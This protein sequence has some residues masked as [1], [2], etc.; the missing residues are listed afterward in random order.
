M[1]PDLFRDPGSVPYGYA[2]EPEPEI[3]L[4]AQGLIWLVLGA[5]AWMVTSCGTGGAPDPKF[6]VTPAEGPAPLTV[7]CDNQTPERYLLGL[8]AVQW[9]WS[10]G[11][12]TADS[13]ERAPVHTY[14]QPGEYT[15]RLTASTS[16]GRRSAE[17][18]VRVTVPEPGDNGGGESGGGEGGG[19]GGSGDGGGDGVADIP[20]RFSR[21]FNVTT[22]APALPVDVTI[23]LEYQGSAAMTALGLVETLPEGWTFEGVVSGPV[24]LVRQ[25][26]SDVEFAWITI[27]AFPVSVTYR[28]RAPADLA[29][30]Q[31]FSGLLRYRFAAGE[32]SVGPVVTTLPVTDG[33]SS[34]TPSADV[35]LTRNFSTEGVYTPGEPVTVTVTVAYT[36]LYP[37]SSLGIRETLPSGWV[38]G[39][40]GGE[41]PP[42][43]YR[44]S[45]QNAEFAW[46]DLPVLPCSFTYQVWPPANASGL[47]GFSGII[48]FRTVGGE[49]TSVPF[50]SILAPASGTIPPD[51]RVA[52]PDV[53][54]MTAEAAASVLA[55]AGL[56]TGPVQWEH[57]DTIAAGVVSAQSPAAGVRVSPGTAVT[58]TISLGPPPQPETDYAAETV[59]N[60]RR[61]LLILYEPGGTA[62]VAVTL[63]KRGGRDIA[64]LTLQE[65]LPEGW[66]FTEMVSGPTPAAPPA[67]GTTGT[68]TFTWMNPGAFPLTCVYRVRA[69][70]DGVETP[71]ISGRL[72]FQTNGGTTG[73]G[74]GPESRL[75]RAGGLETVVAVSLSAVMPECYT[76]GQPVSVTLEISRAGGAALSALGAVLYLPTGWT[77]NGVTQGTAPPIIRS[78]GDQVEF[79]WITPPVL[80]ASCTVSLQPPAD[81][82]VSRVVLSCQA[83]SRTTIGGAVYGPLDSLTLPRRVAS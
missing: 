59:I 18:T 30:D 71:V 12:S 26:G 28:V 43:V 9:T 48:L 67:S 1:K 54:G 8:F 66:A 38:L 82:V 60:L 22:C 14:E 21:T 29:G 35:Q 75:V 74:S 68:L 77:W 33:N 5:L 62:D 31:V 79:A 34:V 10:F 7:T 46:I 83:Q 55:A 2:P 63:E 56:I 23:L 4:M 76:P 49:Q 17:Q 44:Q 37:L 32:L 70:Q 61:E 3:P 58:L 20:P 52:V 47:A 51:S 57:R 11:D 24:D 13:T 41:C 78:D 25:N 27:P 53:T 65:S 6:T 39:T 73:T 81:T 45:E 42:P 36:G 64:L 69:P 16:L 50:V 19:D 72:Q 40:V 15:V 80:P